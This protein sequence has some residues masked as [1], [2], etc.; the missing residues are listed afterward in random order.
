VQEGGLACARVCARVCSRA[1]VCARLVG[2]TG[3]SPG[4]FGRAYAVW[5][6]AARPSSPPP[7]FPRAPS[8]GLTCP[9]SVPGVLPV[10]ACTPQPLCSPPLCPSLQHADIRER[11]VKHSR[12][13]NGALGADY[14]G[15]LKAAAKRMEALREARDAA[16][17]ATSSAAGSA[18]VASAD[19]VGGRSASPPVHTFKPATNTV[20]RKFKRFTHSGAYVGVGLFSFVCGRGVWVWGVGWDGVGGGGGGLVGMGVVQPEVELLA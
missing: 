3:A 13:I 5:V 14:T 16:A 19:L 20:T 4:T 8:Q 11:S 6:C 18:V 7:L 2:C 9:P 12:A 10:A 1:C 17:S 15:P